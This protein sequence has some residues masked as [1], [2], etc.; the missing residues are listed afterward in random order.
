MPLAETLVVMS[1]F[2]LPSRNLL[3]TAIRCST[4]ISSDKSTTACPP[5]FIFCASHEAASCNCRREYKRNIY[6]HQ[7]SS[8]VGTMVGITWYPIV[9][10]NVILRFKLG[11]TPKDKEYYRI[12]LSWFSCGSLSWLNRNLECWFLW[13][14]ENWRAQQKTLGA[15][16]EPTT[17]S[18]HIWHWAGIEPKPHCPHYCAICAPP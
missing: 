5:S 13:R 9:S 6:S 2:S 16:K 17:N 1:S 11:C 18:T 15:R 14:E 10:M 12:S 7:V 3:S 4:V 8:V